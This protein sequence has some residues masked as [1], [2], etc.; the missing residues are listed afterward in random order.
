MAVQNEIAAFFA[1]YVD[2]FARDDAAALSELWDEVGLFP[3]PSGN[4]AMERKAFRDHCV[5]L[6]EFYRGQG[7]VRPEGKLLSANELFADV[8]EAR[9]AYRMFG[10]G[11]KLIAE[12]EHF[13]ILRRRDRWRVSLTVADGEMAA[14][15][16]R[17]AQL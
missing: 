4:F 12:W 9:V 10:E 13:Y 2:A 14:W 8:V 11:E 1:D 16:A 7:V 15:T 17:G 5:S 6:M 3:S